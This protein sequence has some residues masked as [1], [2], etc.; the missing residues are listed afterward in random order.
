MLFSEL[1]WAALSSFG[2]ESVLVCLQFKELQRLKEYCPWNLQRE[3]DAINTKYRDYPEWDA[4]KRRAHVEA[5][6]SVM[7]Q[8][9]WQALSPNLA[10]NADDLCLS[11]RFKYP[12]GFV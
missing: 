10:L 5:T 7:S 1:F 9:S 3:L 4:G 6:K 12:G 2:T 8:T 11:S